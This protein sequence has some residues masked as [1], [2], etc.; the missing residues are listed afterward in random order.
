MDKRPVMMV[1][2][3]ALTVFVLFPQPNACADVEWKVLKQLR[4]KEK[5]LDVDVSLDGQRLYILAEGKLIIYSV[6]QAKGLY[7][8]PVNKSL[9][10]L[11]IS[12]ANESVILLSTSENVVEIIQLQFIP[13]FDLSGSPFMGSLNAPV[14]ICAFIDYQ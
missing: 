10:R 4:I 9:D 2:V 1:S 6:T 11:K 5:P 13:Q 3:L 12:E 8:I 7:A 14:T